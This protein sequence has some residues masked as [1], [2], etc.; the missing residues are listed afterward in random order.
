MNVLIKSYS[1]K[2][3][4]Y[5]IGQ[6][7]VDVYRLRCGRTI[8][9][10][11]ANAQEWPVTNVKFCARCG[12][13]A[14]YEQVNEALAEYQASKKQQHELEMQRQHELLELRNGQRRY[15]APAIQDALGTMAE[16]RGVEIEYFAAGAELTGRFEV[17]GQI[18]DFIL[19]LNR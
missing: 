16:L 6:R 5:H 3:N 13:T 11:N 2:S 14:D 17:G 15:L 1:S 4:L 18:H 7:D 12:N 19:R 8:K 10:D 9:S